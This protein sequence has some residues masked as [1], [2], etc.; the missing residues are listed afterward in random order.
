MKQEVI[1]DNVLS[2]ARGARRLHAFVR[3]VFA[4]EDPPLPCTASAVFI[5]ALKESGLPRISPVLF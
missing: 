4:F 1:G 3:L 2:Q 5:V